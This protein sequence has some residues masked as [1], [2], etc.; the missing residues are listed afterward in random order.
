MGEATGPMTESET[1]EAAALRHEISSQRQ[2]LGR[3]LEAL[4][5]HVSP[6]RIVERRRAALRQRVRQVSEKLMG[7]AEGAGERVGQAGDAIR[8]VPDAARQTVAGSPLTMGLISYGIGVVA[9]S[10]LPASQ[11]EE[12]L[13]TKAQPALD[14]AAEKVGSLAREDVDALKPAFKPPP[15]ASRTMPSAPQTTSEDGL[16]RPQ[17]RSAPPSRLDPH[18]TR[19]RSRLKRAPPRKV[20]RRN[21]ARQTLPSA[22]VEPRWSPTGQP[23]PPNRPCSRRGCQWIAPP[24]HTLLSPIPVLHD[25]RGRA[26]Q[27]WPLTSMW[28]PAPRPRS[29]IR[30]AHFS[31]PR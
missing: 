25:R 5:D 28:R 2:T 15:K 1:T 27:R 26:G 22:H 31:P 14:R 12:E 18:G 9:A 7:T 4:G 3:D 10:L 19:R 21:D 11:G 30:A 16:S 29:A 13:A 6:N 8:G 24:V 20:R 17:P 23:V